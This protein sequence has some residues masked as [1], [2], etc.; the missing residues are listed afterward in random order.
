[1][2][3]RKLL[4]E[5]RPPNFIYIHLGLSNNCFGHHNPHPAGN[6][7][8]NAWLVIYPYILALLFSVGIVR[9]RDGSTKLYVVPQTE[10][11]NF[12]VSH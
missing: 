3:S 7:C 2:H 12:S 10:L 5:K 4:R 11:I 9:I 8:L 1:M 6:T